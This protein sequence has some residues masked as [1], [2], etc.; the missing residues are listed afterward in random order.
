MRSVRG[1]ILAIAI[2][3]LLSI[4]LVYFSLI[5]S[6]S[7][8][9]Q[10]VQQF[11]SFTRPPAVDT[12]PVLGIEF[13][14]VS[15][16][17]GYEIDPSSIDPQQWKSVF[18]RLGVYPFENLHY[19]DIEKLQSLGKTRVSPTSITVAFYPMSMVTK[20]MLDSK[21]TFFQTPT[22]VFYTPTIDNAGE[23]LEIP[24]YVDFPTYEQTIDFPLDLNASYLV[25][26]AIF[27]NFQYPPLED[28]GED[29]SAAAFQKMGKLIFPLLRFSKQ[30]ANSIFTTITSFLIPPVYAYIPACDWDEAVCCFG[31]VDCGDPGLTT[32]GNCEA[33]YSGQSC[34]FDWQCP[35]NNCVHEV[36]CIANNFHPKCSNDPIG[37]CKFPA[38]YGC[39]ISNNC[40][41]TCS[42]GCGGSTPTPT[43]TPTPTLP[44]GGG[45]TPTP[46]P[47]SVCSP[48]QWGSPTCGS[49]GC[50]GCDSS[51][52]NSSGT[53]WN[54]VWN[55]GTCCPGPTVGPT[56]TSTPSPTPGGTPTPPPQAIINARTKLI[57]SSDTS[58]A[59]VSASPD[60]V[61]PTDFY[62]FPNLTP[63][64]RTQTD[65]NYVTWTNV[66]PGTYVLNASAPAGYVIQSACWTRNV[67]PPYSGTGLSVAAAAGETVTWN[68][69][70]TLGSAWTQIQGGDINVANVL[71]SYIPVGAGPRE[72]VLDGAG[73]TPGIVSFGT[74]ADFDSDT[75]GSGATYVSSTDWVIN[76]PGL[77]MYTTNWYDVFVQRFDL[78]GA[79]PDY[80]D[81]GAITQPAP[82]QQPYYVSG[83][84]TTVNAWSVG[85]GETLIVF[86]DGNLTIG[87]QIQITDPTGFIAF[88]VNGD[89]TVNPSVGVAPASGIPQ[90]EGI[91]IT[92]PTG[93]FATGTS[94]A[95]TER[96][97]GEG[98]FVA[99]S[100]LLQRDLES[101]GVNDTTSAELF[102]YNPS[103]RFSMPDE[104]K[105]INVRW[106]EVAP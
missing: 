52:C 105:D 57:S 78:A 96:F 25:A 74:A 81:P 94:G 76:E 69:G 100:F 3:L 30:G 9:Q 73:G 35:T 32:Y 77:S 37:G 36:T 49:N 7:Q 50:G 11:R 86:V 8:L 103:L 20:E 22:S 93:T 29:P 53:G 91:F 89:I 15:N 75:G 39:M 85:A 58:C 40:T 4:P 41:I 18:E 34:E 43:R 14:I 5:A 64:T 68:L 54:C 6:Q 84:L 71:E 59:A 88:I 17:P 51:Q 27:F 62:T 90:V 72:F 79:A 99:G 47:G 2:F 21:N 106:E 63:P 66:T 23:I 16:V 80:T 10:I 28:L 44:G 104:M 61:T 1:F 48:G 92:A 102:I 55:P 24:I 46:T 26:N 65:S 98:I 83:D 19:L 95:G 45:P 97:V 67:T 33:P 101:V 12:S 38:C 60:F 87:D 31:D 13:R 42:T 82:R 56:P 70:L